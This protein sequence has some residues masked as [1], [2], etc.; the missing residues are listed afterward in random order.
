MRLRAARGTHTRPYVSETNCYIYIYIYT[1]TYT[2][3]ADALDGVLNGTQTDMYATIC[4]PCTIQTLETVSL[5]LADKREVEIFTKNIDAVCTNLNNKWCFPS[6]VC[7]YF[8]IYI[9]MYVCMYVCMYKSVWE[10]VLAAVDCRLADVWRAKSFALYAPH[11]RKVYVQ[12]MSVDVQCMSVDVKCMSV[13]HGHFENF[14]I[15]SFPSPTV[16]Y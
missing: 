15:I 6:W 8:N 9:C 12:C 3:T 11:E 4:T 7:M 2:H 13:S 16:W 5:V 10:Y 14:D 1:H